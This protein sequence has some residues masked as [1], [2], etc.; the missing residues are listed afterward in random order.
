MKLPSMRKFG[1]GRLADADRLQL[2]PQAVARA[3]AR[4]VEVVVRRRDRHDAGVDA[5]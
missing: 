4:L 1:P 3:D 2:G 5:A